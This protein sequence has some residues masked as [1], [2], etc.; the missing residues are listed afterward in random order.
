MN[1]KSRVERF[2]C[3][4]LIIS[5]PRFG[6]EETH[7]SRVNASPS[8]VLDAVGTLDDG[9]DAIRA[10]IAD[11]AR[12]GSSPIQYRLEADFRT[13]AS[14]FAS[15]A[16]LPRKAPYLCRHSSVRWMPSNV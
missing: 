13:G 11:D 8:V 15:K 12:A 3:R 6:F 14:P 16:A 2:R 9:D 5:F 1:S 10:R 4:W 7:E